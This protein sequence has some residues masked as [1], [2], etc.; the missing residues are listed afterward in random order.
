MPKKKPPENKKHDP[1]PKSLYSGI[2]KKKRG[3]CYQSPSL[4]ATESL[5]KKLSEQKSLT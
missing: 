2:E 1:S 3:T 4:R 5:E